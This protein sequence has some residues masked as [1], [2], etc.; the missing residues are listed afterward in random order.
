MNA[1]VRSGSQSH[2]HVCERNILFL[3]FFNFFYDRSD[4]FLTSWK[5]RRGKGSGTKCGIEREVGGKVGLSL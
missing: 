2:V 5:L 1:K 3:I 4:V